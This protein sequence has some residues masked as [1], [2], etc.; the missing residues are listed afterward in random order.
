MVD[1]INLYLLNEL[2]DDDRTLIDLQKGLSCNQIIIDTHDL[3]NRLSWL[4][5]K[6]YILFIE[7]VFSAEFNKI[8]GEEKNTDF[9]DANIKEVW[10]RLSLSGRN[11]LNQNEPFFN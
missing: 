5:Q 7:P 4:F 2:S 9:P 6:G 1:H 8:I 3:T 11:I 10:F